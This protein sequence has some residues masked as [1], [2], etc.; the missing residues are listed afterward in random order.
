L[1]PFS[2]S[3]LQDL[4]KG[5]KKAQ[6]RH[7]LLLTI[8]SQ[9]LRMLWNSNFQSEKTIWEC[10]DLLSYIGGNV[11]ESWDIILAHSSHVLTLIASQKLRLWQSLFVPITSKP[12]LP[13]HD[14]HLNLKILCGVKAHQDQPTLTK[15]ITMLKVIKIFITFLVT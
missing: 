15:F 5:L 9:Q 7:H 6:F 4:S 8:L 2:I 11:F 12:Q 3:M 1:N 13:P 10:W 14:A